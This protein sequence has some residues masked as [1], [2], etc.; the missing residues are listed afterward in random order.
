ML[1]RTAV[2]KAAYSTLFGSPRKRL[3][4]DLDA[5]DGI[6]AGELRLLTQ[7]IEGALTGEI[8]GRGEGGIS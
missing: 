1:S 3:G 6:R 2:P 7:P 5:D 8:P 4:G